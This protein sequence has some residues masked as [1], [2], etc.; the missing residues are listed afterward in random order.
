VFPINDK[1]T[2][3]DLAFPANVSHMMPPREVLRG[4]FPNKREYERVFSDWFFN[5]LK[6]LEVTPRE[7][8]D[9]GKALAHIKCVMGSFEPAH[10]DK[11]AAV[12]FLLNEWFSEVKAVPK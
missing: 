1:L 3:L 12:A 4:D 9:K 7:G 10:E 5:G 6:S 11:T 8:V 2:K